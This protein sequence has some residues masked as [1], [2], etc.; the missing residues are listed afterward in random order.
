MNSGRKKHTRYRLAGRQK[1]GQAPAFRYGPLYTGCPALEMAVERFYQAPDQEKETRFWGLVKGLNYA[2]QMETRVLVPVELE[3]R[4]HQDQLSWARAPIPPDRAKDLS[5]WVLTAP[6]G[7]KLLPAFTFWKEADA[8]DVT[9]GLPVVELP[10]QQAMEEVLAREE[11]SGLVLNPWGRSATL[12]RSLLQA[13][14][15]AGP[16]DNEPGEADA[17]CGKQAAAE[18]RWEEAA[19]A[20]A[21]AAGQ[22][23]PEGMRLLAGCCQAGRGVSRDRRKAVSWWKK[24]AALGDVLSMVALGDS[25]AAGTARTPGDPGRALMA[26]RKA[27][28]MGELE[29]DIGSWPLV[30]LRLAQAEASFTDPD[31][32][33]CLLGEAVQGLLIL[34]RADQKDLPLERET[35]RAE[36]RDAAGLM[37]DCLRGKNA[38]AGPL[39]ALLRQLEAGNTEPLLLS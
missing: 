16:P 19:D 32:A 36:L 6:K 8:S 34:C 18:G 39:E 27:R 29:L 13:L 28:T 22:G 5:H 3:P 14:L 20:F 33:V 35:L 11:L 30:C 17:A 31:R 21:A 2:L 26:Y 37:A 15:Y 24:A 9:K 38:D 7:Q 1:K 4:G 25:Y 23:S 12:D 10:L